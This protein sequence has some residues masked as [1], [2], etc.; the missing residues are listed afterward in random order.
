MRQTLSSGHRVRE[1]R[2]PLCAD[3]DLQA[4]LAPAQGPFFRGLIRALEFGAWAFRLLGIAMNPQDQLQAIKATEGKSS[5]KAPN[6]ELY[7]PTAG[8]YSKALSPKF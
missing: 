7:N 4:P 1:G 6:P 2:H 3:A 8:K 5:R